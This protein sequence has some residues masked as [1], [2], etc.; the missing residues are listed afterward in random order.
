MQW[1]KL[2]LPLPHEGVNRELWD[3]S[4]K[5]SEELQ[6]NQLKTVMGEK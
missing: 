5:L 4:E 1:F 3:L 6:Q 2:E